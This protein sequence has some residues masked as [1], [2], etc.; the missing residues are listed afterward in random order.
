MLREWVTAFRQQVKEN[1]TQLLSD[2]AES[3]QRRIKQSDRKESPDYIE[4]KVRG[5]LENMHVIEPRV[6]IVVKDVSWESSRDNEF[7][8]ALRKALPANDLRRWFD[9]FTAVQERQSTATR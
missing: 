2:I 9:E 3:I 1:E 4:A 8:A 5:G 6:R 7:S